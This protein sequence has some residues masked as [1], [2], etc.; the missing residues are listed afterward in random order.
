MK[1]STCFLAVLFVVSGCGKV[2]PTVSP[3]SVGLSVDSGMR[4]V[5]SS[6]EVESNTIIP[7]MEEFC[8]D[9]PA[10]NYLTLLSSFNDGWKYI[11]PLHADGLNCTVILFT[12]PATK[13]EIAEMRALVRPTTDS[14]TS[15]AGKGDSNTP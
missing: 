14:S 10:T 9:T 8:R 1:F 13:A 15:D 2:D 3:A 6:I 12:K 7:K 5:D 11:G 4:T